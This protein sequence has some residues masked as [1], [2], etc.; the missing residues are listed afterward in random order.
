[1]QTRKDTRNRP[2]SGKRRSR[3]EGVNEEEHGEKT[4]RGLLIEK[5]KREVDGGD[6]DKVGGGHGVGV[7]KRSKGEKD[8]RGRKRIPNEKEIPVR[9]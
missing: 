8:H 6:G 2:L 4:G 7:E 9:N 5:G 1:L 3:T